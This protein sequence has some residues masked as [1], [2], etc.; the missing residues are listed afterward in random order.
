[1]KAGALMNV[2]GV[3]VAMMSVYLFAGPAFGVFENC[4]PWLHS[5]HCLSLAAGNASSVVN[6]TNVA[7]TT[8]FK[9]ST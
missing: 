4:P 7:I 9:A 8:A 1:M 5:E 2:V 6:V 3:L